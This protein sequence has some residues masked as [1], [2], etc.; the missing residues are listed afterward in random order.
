MEMRLEPGEAA[1]VTEIYLPQEYAKSRTFQQVLN[2]SLSPQRVREHFGATS[3]DK[4]IPT[5]P[6][7]LQNDYSALRGSIIRSERAFSGYSLYDCTGAFVGET[8]ERELEWGSCVRIIDVPRPD[9]LFLSKEDVPN[10][11]LFQRIVRGIFA[12]RSHH[13]PWPKLESILDVEE[14]EVDRIFERLQ[15]WTDEGSTLL[16]GFLGYHLVEITRGREQE[17]LLTSHFAVLNRYRRLPS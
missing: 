4:I 6:E 9:T 3:D 12:L 11:K 2:D 7:P 13:E 16:Y 1:V 8:G 17:I 15:Q 14:T 5:L 10:E